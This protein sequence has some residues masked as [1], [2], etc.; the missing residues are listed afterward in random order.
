MK[1][2]S[3]KLTDSREELFVPKIIDDVLVDV[4]TVGIDETGKER[5]QCESAERLPGQIPTQPFFSSIESKDRSAEK[6]AGM[7]IGP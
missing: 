5:N 2:E 6:E 4:P 1:V 7:H 3:L